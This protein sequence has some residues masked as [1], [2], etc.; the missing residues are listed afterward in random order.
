[1]REILGEG[2]FYGV[3]HA[4][5]MLFETASLNRLAS[6]SRSEPGAG[7]TYDLVTRQTAFLA[8][9]SAGW[10]KKRALATASE[11]FLLYLFSS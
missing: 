4:I 10:L 2:G 3:V 11:V 6:G 1:M 7:A 5:G 9:R 8:I